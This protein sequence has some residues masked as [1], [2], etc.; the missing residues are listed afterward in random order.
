MNLK[1]YFNNTF[2]YKERQEY[3][4]LLPNSANNIPKSKNETNQKVSPSLNVNIEYLKSKY[5]LMINSDVKTRELSLPIK[6]KQ[7]PAILLFI[8]GMVDETTI[9]N[10]VLQPLL[11][12]N[13]IFMQNETKNTVSKGYRISINNPKT[14]NISNEDFI[15]N[16]LIPHNSVSKENHFKDIIKKVNSGFCALFVD[17]I[18]LAFCVETKGFKGRSVA[19]PITESI[20]RGPQE[21]F[22]ENIR[23]NTSMLRKIINNENL[24]IEELN[25]GE[26]NRTQVAICYIKNIANDDLVAEVKYRINSLKLDSLLSS[27][28]LEQFIKDKPLNSF[29]QAVSTERPDRV[30]SYLLN[31]RIAIIVNGTPFVLVVPAIFIDFLDSGED[32]NLSYAFANFLRFIRLVALFFAIFLPGMYVAITNFHQ[33]LIPSELLFAIANAHEAIPFPV[34]FEIILME[35]YFEL[36][37]EA[38]L[39]V[40]SSFSTTV[41]IIGAL[42]LGDAAVS[43]NIVSPILII[44][45]AFTGICGFAIPDF[46]LTT[47]IRIYRFFYILLG[48]L[49]GFLGIAFG[50]F[51]HFI[52][53]T[54]ISSFGVPYFSPYLP[55]ADLNN[56]NGYLVKP[57]WKREKRSRFLNTKRPQAEPQYSMNWNKNKNL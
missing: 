37:R 56:N 43:A 14:S 7:T 9:T 4:F 16:S 32:K 23:I 19:E 3:D 22:V 31:G 10:S 27:G 41:G 53:L 5:N 35:I 45:V 44:I 11:L 25:V 29:P 52:I 18:D 12:K 6:N 40:S 34:I 17:N 36:I 38:G 24:V 46:S 49:A 26:I 57:V 48:F 33:E 55:S 39:R 30:S 47:S 42:I 50:F 20:I 51:V 2:S 21:G 8:D 54:N 28:Q 15:Y 13:S 1:N